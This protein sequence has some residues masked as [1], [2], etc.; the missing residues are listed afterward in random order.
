MFQPH[1]CEDKYSPGH[2]IIMS[3]RSAHVKDTEATL[4]KRCWLASKPKSLPAEENPT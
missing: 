2:W 3:L 4:E 1:S